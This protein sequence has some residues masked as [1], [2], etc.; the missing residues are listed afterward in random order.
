MCARR[1]CVAGDV[2][3]SFLVHLPTGGSGGAPLITETETD[4]QTWSVNASSARRGP[5]L[6]E[7]RGFRLTSVGLAGVDLGEVAVLVR[8]REV[9]QRMKRILGLKVV[10][11]GRKREDFNALKSHFKVFTVTAEQRNEEKRRRD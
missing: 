4:K 10:Y 9:V 11:K 5:S 2:R 7:G 1:G 3:R 8:R 6:S